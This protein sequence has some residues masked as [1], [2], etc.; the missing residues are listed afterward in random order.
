MVN[1]RFKIDT[2]GAKKALESGINA[3]LKEVQKDFLTKYYS[4][5]K[6]RLLDK[7]IQGY[8]FSKTV[9]VLAEMQSEYFGDG[10]VAQQDP[11]AFLQPHYIKAVEK[12]I[13]ENFAM[14][15]SQVSSKSDLEIVLLTDD[16][17]GF[18]KEGDIKGTTPI[19]W[20][21]YFLIGALDTDLYWVDAETYFL[22][23]GE[24]PQGQ[25]GR[26][27]VGHLW[28]INSEESKKRLDALLRGSGKSLEQIKHPQSGKAGKNWFAD[29]ITPAEIQSLIIM[30][31][32][33][34]SIEFVQS[35]YANYRI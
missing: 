13:A 12:E 3:L 7:S 26:F 28:H 31:S 19:Q 29:V 20:L 33:N 10:L 9:Q 35:K 14:A 24:S 32:I 6:M 21:V 5:V 25:L 1:F 17:L 30:P 16:F 4:S 8:F 15:A 23:T 11:T 18:G 34:Q 22:F 27:G 2:V